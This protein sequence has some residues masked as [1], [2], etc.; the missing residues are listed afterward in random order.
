MTA[1]VRR[2]AVSAVALLAVVLAGCDSRSDPGGGPVDS[3]AA[4]MTTSSAGSAPTLSVAPTAPTVLTASTARPTAPTTDST[5][6][7]PVAATAESGPTA[8]P[9]G[10]V[11]DPSVVASPNAAAPVELPEGGRT[12]FPDRR[13]AALY[14]HPGI[15][16]LGVLGQQDL[17]ESIARARELA[18]DIQPYSDVPVLPAFEIIATIAD[19]GPGPDGDYSAESTVEELRPWVQQAAAAG[20]Y[21]VLDLQP[22]RT[23]F[24][25]QAQRYAELLQL[26]GVGLALDPEWR[27][28]AGQVHLEQIGS[29]DAAEVNAV[30]GWLADLTAAA[31]LPQKL[32]LLHQFRL[33]MIR[34]IDALDL[35]HPELAVVVQMDGQGSQAAK[36][37]TW[38]A[39]TG[40]APPGIRF[41]WKN[42]LQRDTPVLGPADTM[43]QQPTPV[44]ISVE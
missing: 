10:S 36:D 39:I 29:V 19:A 22:G 40:A 27:L 9:V 14:G 2:T 12:L 16:G 35:S 44:L 5:A 7:A 3:T 1:A 34:N 18:A 26:P 42:F 25:T 38:A 17:P 31:G 28:A 4:A 13:I 32:L 15:A 6:G 30:A 11:T 33:S 20:L 37:E 43:A 24:L 23:D 8:A 41:G 21:V